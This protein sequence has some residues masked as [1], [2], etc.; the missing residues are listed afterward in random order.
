MADYTFLTQDGA[1]E[2]MTE[3]NN[4]WRKWYEIWKR[5]L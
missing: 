4:G 2:K 3:W 5:W 1:N